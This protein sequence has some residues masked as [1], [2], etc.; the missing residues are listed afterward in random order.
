MTGE[1]ARTAPSLEPA[2]DCQR[3]TILI[4]DDVELNR[5]I[6]SEA[7][8]GSYH[9]REAENG[10][11][12]MELLLADPGRVCAILLDIVM[13][14][15]DGFSVLEE[16]RRNGLLARIPVFLITADSSEANM[17]RGYDLGAVDI[18]G[19]PV[20]PYFLRRRV[21]GVVELYRAREQLDRRVDLQDRQLAQQ[22]EEIQQLNRSIIE[23]LATA[24]EFRSGESGEHVRRISRLTTWLLCELRRRG[25]PG[26]EFT[27]EQIGQIAAAAILH[28]VGK[29]AVPD[30]VLNKPGRLTA[31]EFELMKTHTV[32]GCELLEQIPQYH[33]NPLFQYAH[34]IC[35]HHHERVDG[36]GYPDGLKG[37]ELTIWSQVVALADVYD[38]LTN[39]RVYKPAFTHEE[40]MEMIRTGQC[41]QFAPA[42]VDSLGQVLARRAA[43]S[44]GE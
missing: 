5:A 7:F 29:I 24:I 28:D 21:E 27:D 6:L 12:A 22:A 16:L 36:R 19:K 37:E 1:P 33:T 13:P 44:A 3:D 2:G 15:M 17:R 31:E 14:V 9:V 42:L 32:R 10:A 41:G 4:V 26:C 38:A 39:K 40:A 35:R 20:L 43:E 11:Q 25:Y 18:I 34:D 30:Q 8:R 23:S